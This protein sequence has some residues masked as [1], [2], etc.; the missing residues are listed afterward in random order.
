LAT[1]P[2]VSREYRLV[3]F[4]PQKRRRRGE[5]YDIRIDE[6]SRVSTCRDAFGEEICHHGIEG[7]IE[8]LPARNREN[9]SRIAPVRA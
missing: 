5:I 4:S 3:G 1:L 7:P 2:G 8:R 9:A 6:V